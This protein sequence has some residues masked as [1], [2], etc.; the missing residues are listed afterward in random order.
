MEI[1]TYWKDQFI[2][3]PQCPCSHQA[4]IRINK[5][6]ATVMDFTAPEVVKINSNPYN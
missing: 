3:T 6:D 2:N 1:T 5:Y 4:V